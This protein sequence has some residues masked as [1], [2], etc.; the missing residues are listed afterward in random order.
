MTSTSFEYEYKITED[1][2]LL[3]DS[4]HIGYGISVSEKKTGRKILHIEDITVSKAKL[5]E[6]VTLCNSLELSP[7]HI[8]DVIEDFLA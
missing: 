1:T 2:Y 3:E 7:I 8:Y 4:K 6:L 5:S